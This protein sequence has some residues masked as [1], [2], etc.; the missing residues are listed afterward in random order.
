MAESTQT[1]L[2]NLFR[3][4]IAPAPYV[5]LCVVGDP[6]DK[7]SFTVWAYYVNG[8]WF[9]LPGV[10][11]SIY[12]LGNA[13]RGAG[14]YEQTYAVHY[15]GFTY[16]LLHSIDAPA[17]PKTQASATLTRIAREHPRLV[18]V[19][20]QPEIDA[21]LNQLGAKQ[22][23]T[24]YFSIAFT[25]RLYTLAQVKPLGAGTLAYSCQLDPTAFDAALKQ[26]GY[27]LVDPP[28]HQRGDGYSVIALPDDGGRRYLITDATDLQEHRARE[29]WFGQRLE[30]ELAFAA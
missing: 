9:N 8:E 19:P 15:G 16:Y 10:E 21:L 22:Q 24:F 14:Y 2:L 11:S 12:D 30:R 3:E 26:H 18:N 4:R 6:A 17:M 5:L 29:Q 23:I 27:R 13:E 20:P 1:D 25:D 7:R 28:T